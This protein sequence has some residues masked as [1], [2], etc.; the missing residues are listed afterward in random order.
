[1]FSLEFILLFAIIVVTQIV[2]TMKD[3]SVVCVLSN[4]LYLLYFVLCVRTV[5]RRQL[6]IIEQNKKK[7][8]LFTNNKTLK[9][10]RFSSSEQYRQSF[11]DCKQS[12]RRIPTFLSRTPLLWAKSLLGAT[13]YFDFFLWS[14]VFFS[15]NIITV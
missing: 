5:W 8:K 4:K 3:K 12:D 1:M 2:I 13:G 7:L 6:F 9:R 10:I 15:A 14:V 11:L